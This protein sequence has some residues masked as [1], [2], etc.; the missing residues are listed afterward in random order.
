[1][2]VFSLSVISADEVGVR[3]HVNASFG[4]QCGHWQAVRQAESKVLQQ[5][6][7]EQ[8]EFHFGQPLTHATAWTC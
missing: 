2:S 3:T 7:E 4:L 8:E 5:Y 1:M 6:S